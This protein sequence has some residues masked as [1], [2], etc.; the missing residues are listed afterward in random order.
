MGMPLNPLLEAGDYQR[1]AKTLGVRL[2]MM[3]SLGEF[4]VELDYDLAPLTSEHFRRLANSGA[5][6]GMRFFAVRPNGYAATGAGMALIR[7]ELNAKPFLRG[8]LGLLRQA[9]ESGGGFFLCQ[10][11]LP[12]AD[13]RYV[14]FGRLVSGDQRLDAISVGVQVLEI[15]EIL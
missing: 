2:R 8:S 15:R 14:N 11:A 9:A 5:F 6:D 7:S 3:T 13:G 12:L 10:T 4:E 1:L